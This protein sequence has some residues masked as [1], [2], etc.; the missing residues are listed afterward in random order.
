MPRTTQCQSCRTI[1]NLPLNIAAGKRLRC[2]KCGVKFAVTVADANSESPLAAPLDAD[3]TLTGLDLPRMPSN[4]DDLP[5]LGS[6]KDLRETFD[7]PLVS[8]RDAERQGAS[9]A[10][11]VGDATALFQDR[12]GPRRR[13]TAGDVRSQ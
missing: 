13:G 3:P 10:Q 8:A 7:L 2:P 6:E 11:A 5:I 4:P 1:L 9:P 12:P